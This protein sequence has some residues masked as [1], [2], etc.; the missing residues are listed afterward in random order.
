MMNKKLLE[1]CNEYL[2]SGDAEELADILDVVQSL[3]VNQ[4]KTMEDIEKVRQDKV[5]NRGGFEER[6][7]LEWVEE[8]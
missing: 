8:K 2:E 5:E 3:V 4:G 7:F 1:E 6:I